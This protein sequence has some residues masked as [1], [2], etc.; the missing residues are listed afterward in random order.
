MFETFFQRTDS[1]TLGVCNGC[2]MVSLLKDIIPGAEAWPR[3]TRNKIE[4]FEGRYA[5]LEILASPSILFKGMEGSRIPIPVAHGEGFTNF[6]RT[7]SAHP[8]DVIWR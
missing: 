5:T 6:E 3:F 4:Q 7:G 8:T 2:Q 1:F